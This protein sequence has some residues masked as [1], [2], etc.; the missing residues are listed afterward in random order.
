MEA[1]LTVPLAGCETPS[2]VAVKHKQQHFK[3]CY[4]LV[5]PSVLRPVGVY[6]WDV[7]V[8]L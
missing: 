1:S 5:I 8:C 4:K 7:D 3:G 6:R 2:T